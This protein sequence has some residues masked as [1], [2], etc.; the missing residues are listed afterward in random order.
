MA[1]MKRHLAVA[2]VALLLAPA[3]LLAQDGAT[4]YRRD[5]SS[6]HDMGVDRAPARDALQTMTAERVLAAMESGRI[7]RHR[8]C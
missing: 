7:H 3:S 4:L 5:C 8:R 1:R 2:V 6:C